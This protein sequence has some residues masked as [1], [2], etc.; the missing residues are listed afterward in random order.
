MSNLPRIDRLVEILVKKGL[1]HIMIGPSSDMEY[2]TKIAPI[3]DERFKVL[4]ISKNGKNFAIAP[5][6]CKDEF[7]EELLPDIPVYLWGDDTGP[8]AA[9]DMAFGE[10]G[11]SDVTVALNDGIRAIDVLS[12]QKKYQLKLVDGDELVSILR[13]AKSPEE[14][15]RQK[16]VGALADEVLCE[17]ENFIRP[18][19]REYDIWLKLRD[20][21][22]RR[23]GGKISGIFA[24]GPNGA[25]PHYTKYDRVIE[26]ND[27]MVVDFGGTYRGYR[28]DTTRTFVIGEP[29]EEQRKV[30]EVV[31]KA[32]KAGEAFVK[33]GIRACDLDR[34][35]RGVIEEAGYGSYFTHRTGHGIG[36]IAH[37]PP[38]IT[39]TETTT[40][41]EGM[42]FSIEPGIYLPG[43]F[44]VRIENCVVV[45][46]DGCEAFT[47]YPRELRV[48]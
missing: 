14:I 19:L 13:R 46:K 9:I 4:V 37:E 34:T 29:T 3:I 44:G 35:V 7:E 8:A 21:F 36:I 12:M 10:H 24:S 25:M 1:E 16:A 27:L 48:I 26:K 18:G 30:Y 17:I 5:Q 42:T 6:I 15:E 47:H 40:L 45:T 28:S 20:E 43:K 2:L 32:Q 39:A 22:E 11:L 41:Q 31:L 38:Y 33:P 23:G